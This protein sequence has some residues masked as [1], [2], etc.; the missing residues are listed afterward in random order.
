LHEIVPIFRRLVDLGF[1]TEANEYAC[2]DGNDTAH[3]EKDS[4]GYH[5]FLRRRNGRFRCDYNPSTGDVYGWSLSSTDRLVGSFST[6]YDPDAE[7]HAG[8]V[9]AKWLDLSEGEPGH[10]TYTQMDVQNIHQL[11]ISMCAIS[12]SLNADHPAK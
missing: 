5:L 4:S 8:A 11:I 9:K 6:Q 7:T 3:V 10:V 1:T 12:S 2:K